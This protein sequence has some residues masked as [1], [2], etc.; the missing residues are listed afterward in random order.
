MSVISSVY[1]A[2]DS[3]LSTLLSATHKELVNPYFP[4]M[5]ET[6]AL[7][8]G[9]SFRVSNGQ[10]TNRQLSCNLSLRREIV[11]INSIVTRG[12]DRDVAIRKVSEKQLLEDQYT[13]INQVE[14]E[15]TIQEL[16][17]KLEFSIDR[18]IDFIFND[19]FNYLYIESIFTV[20]YF[21]TYI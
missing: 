17:S 2:V 10:N 6:L 7:N 21:D 11:I 3:T 8:R 5:N 15:P 20:E 9:Y 1:D 13:I 18:G 14:K 16:V 4:E 19:K 12:T